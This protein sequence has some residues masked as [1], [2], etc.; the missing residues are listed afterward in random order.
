MNFNTLLS[1]IRLD[2]A[3][4]LLKNTKSSILEISM[5]CGFG[6]ERAFYRQFKAILGI[7]PKDYRK[8]YVFIPQ[9]EPTSSNA[10]IK[11]KPCTQDDPNTPTI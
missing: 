7:S 11:I 1:M 9:I 5:E 3:K 6:S 10:D 2:E 4:T 8:N